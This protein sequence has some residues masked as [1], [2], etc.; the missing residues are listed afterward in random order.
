[1]SIYE[2]YIFPRIVDKIMQ[3]KPIRIQRSK[4]VPLAEGRILEIG[5]GSG[6]NLAYYDKGKLEKLWGLDPSAELRVFAERR[7]METGI[8]VEF[9]GL[10]GEDIPLEAASVDTVLVT[11][12]LCTIPDPIAALREMRRVLRPGGRLVYTE[13]GL[14]PDE[15]VRRW[16]NRLNGFWAKIA[17]GCNLNRDIPALLAQTDFRSESAETMYIPGLK[18]MSFNYWGT[19]T[20]G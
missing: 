20:P 12:T 7:A 18:P 17:G 14:A 2:R 11:Y 8:D 19:A 9:I 15:N 1:M 3:S 13:H 16:Q 4:V 6:L 10:T 5:I